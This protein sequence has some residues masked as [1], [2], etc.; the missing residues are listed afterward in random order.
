MVTC[1]GSAG[2][3]MTPVSLEPSGT[4]STPGTTAGRGAWTSSALRLGKNMSGSRDSLMSMCHISGHPDVFV[5]LMVVT[6]PTSFP[7]TSTDGSGAPIK[8]GLL[9]QTAEQLSTIGQ[10]LEDSTHPELSQTIES[11][12]SREESRSHVLP[13]LIISTE[14]ELSGTM[15][16]VIMKNQLSAKTLRDTLLS[17]DR[18]SPTSGFLEQIQTNH[19]LLFIYLFFD[20][21]CVIKLATED[22]GTTR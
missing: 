22:W 6:D 4:G 20:I 14:T 7:R 13:F 1:T 10:E 8:P 12:S 18:H 3:I 9:Q 11:K 15:L 21:Y 5:T 2:K 19:Y 16:L 17:P